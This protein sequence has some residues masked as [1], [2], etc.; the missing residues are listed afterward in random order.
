MDRMN[1]KE[2]NAIRADIGENVLVHRVADAIYNAIASHEAKH[3][4]GKSCARCGGEQ[5][6][7]IKPGSVCCWFCEGYVACE[8]REKAPKT[9]ERNRLPELIA[10]VVKARPDLAEKMPEFIGDAWVYGDA[11]HPDTARLIVQGIVAEELG[12]WDKQAHLRFR[13]MSVPFCNEGES[14]LEAQVALLL[15]ETARKA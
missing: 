15:R 13:M 6:S 7:P 12:R 9:D 10:R 14:F 8:T 3:H 2:W 11:I 4:G 1:T 5:G